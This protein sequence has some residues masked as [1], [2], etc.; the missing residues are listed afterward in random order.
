MA[1]A[2]TAEVKGVA[3]SNDD[4]LL[5]S[6][7]ADCTIKVWNLETEKVIHTLRGHTDQVKIFIL[8]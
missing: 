8:R 2:H 4:K 6:A 7:S 1:C 3:V 5:V